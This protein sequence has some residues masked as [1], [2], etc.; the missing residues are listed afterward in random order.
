M[1]AVKTFSWKNRNSNEFL[2]DNV[3]QG[4][5]DKIYDSSQITYEGDYN[6][7]I[8]LHDRVT[9]KVTKMYYHHSV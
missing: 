2:V 5:V 6:E 8:L 4:D 1:E 3:P 7:W 9:G